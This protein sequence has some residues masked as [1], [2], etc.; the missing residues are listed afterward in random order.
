VKREFWLERWEFDQIGFHQREVNPVLKH[1]WPQLN[2]PPERA[3]LVP[4]CGKSLDMR[5]LEDLGH[6]VWGVELSQKAIEAYFAEGGETPEY[7]PAE[8]PEV[9]AFYQG[10]GTTIY[11]GD[12]LQLS[13][14]QVKGTGA[15]FDRGALVAL[16]GPQRAHYADHIQRIIPEQ[17]VILLLTLEYDQSR[18]PGPPFSVAADEVEALYGDRCD[19]EQLNSRTSAALP[20]KFSEAGLESVTECVY[21]ITKEH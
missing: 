21:R 2:I 18:V 10:S 7:H 6:R 20:P 9:L 12:Y 1:Y 11:L 14:P 16:P 4:L 8:A 19:I 15:V 13:A 17:A 3:V 5:W